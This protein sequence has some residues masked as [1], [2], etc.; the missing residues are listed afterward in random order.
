MGWNTIVA[1]G[2]A[3]YIYTYVSFRQCVLLVVCN[4]QQIQGKGICP[5][6]P[7]THH[8]FASGVSYFWIFPEASKSHML[9]VLIPAVGWKETTTPRYEPQVAKINWNWK[10]EA[11]N[12]RDTGINKSRILLKVEELD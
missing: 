8:V 2:M 9:L 10:M 5:G 3:L 1:F 11:W 4:L 7:V 12:Y 6:V